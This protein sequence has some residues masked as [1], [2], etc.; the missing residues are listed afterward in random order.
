MS[1]LQ[2]L[3][4]FFSTFKDF[5]W[6]IV[7]CI[8][9]FAIAMGFLESSVVIY[10]RL[11]LYP[12]GFRFPLAP[13]STALILTEIIREGATVIMLICAGF[14]A[15]K[16]WYTRFAYFL[17][18]FALWDI[19]YYVF[20]K[21]LINW[22][23]NLLTWDIL[24]LIPTNWVGPVITPVIVSLTMIVFAFIIIWFDSNKIK[25]KISTID[26]FFILSGS[27]IL[28]LAFTWDY[29]CFVLGR[30]PF[31]S[32]MVMPEKDLI[33]LSAQY[34]PAKFNWLLFTFAEITICAGIIRFCIKNYKL[35]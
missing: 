23:G 25:I 35:N 14:L 11:S 10:L 6:K 4:N 29:S 16:T 26:W 12:S 15:G 13:M 8:A 30:C 33:N 24:F 32:L 21:I 9:L 28:I 18:A 22:P 34:I 20:L 19:F 5:P 27:V 31:S 3:I 1:Y 17:Y 2:R 7:T